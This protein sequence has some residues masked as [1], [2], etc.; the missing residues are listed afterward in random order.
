[1]GT[2]NDDLQHRVLN[3][4]RCTIVMQISMDELNFT[5]VKMS[6]NL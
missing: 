1:M 4:L 2:V 6:I 3:V 5:S